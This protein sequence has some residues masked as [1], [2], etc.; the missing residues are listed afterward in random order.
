MKKVRLLVLIAIIGACLALWA[1]GGGG[2]G[3]PP[4]DEP[5]PGTAVDT[6]GD[7]I[8]DTADNCSTV[9]NADQTDQILADGSAGS[10]GVGD[11]CE[12]AGVADTYTWI[13]NAPL[14]VD[15]AAQGLLAN[16]QFADSVVNFGEE[17]AFATGTC[18][19]TNVDPLVAST[20]LGGTVAIDAAGLFVYTPPG[21]GAAIP[22]AS[23]DGDPGI[24]SDGVTVLD[25]FEIIPGSSE[26]AGVNGVPSPVTVT[27]ADTAWFVQNN[28]TSTTPDGSLANPF[29]SLRGPRQP[30]PTDPGP[31]VA[32]D[33]IFVLSGDGTTTGQDIGIFLLNNQKLIGQGIDLAYPGFSVNGSTPAPKTIM[34][35]SI[36]PISG[37]PLTAGTPPSVTNTGLAEGGVAV[38][39]PVEL[40][41]NNEVAGLR[42]VDSNEEKI[43]G[44]LF[45][46][47]GITGFN[48]HHNV[49]EETAG[50][51]L[52]NAEDIFLF[53]AGGTGVV[54][55]NT[56]TDSGREAIRFI[57]FDPAVPAT[58]PLDIIGTLTITGNTITSP[59]QSGIHI[60]LA[61]TGAATSSLTATIDGGNSI[62]GIAAGEDAIDVQLHDAATMN[63]TIDGATLTADLTNPGDQGINF[64][65]NEDSQAS[66]VVT[67]TSISGFLLNGMELQ[68]NDDADLAGVTTATVDALVDGNTM[69]GNGTGFAAGSDAN[70]LF[71]L[72]LTSN[73]STGNTSGTGY[74]ITAAAAELTFVHDET[75]APNTGDPIV[76]D[77][78][79]PQLTTIGQGTC[80]G[81]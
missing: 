74:R 8:A 10:N 27:M 9:A 80:G 61:S 1:C 48:I 5:G 65:A 26:V 53:A 72:E 4:T 44:G 7:G 35:P 70:T 16:A 51:P 42:L 15:A 45:P 40:A 55:N 73:S 54:A 69:T 36:N 71:C 22:A 47:S 62:S 56:M 12:P 50:S 38:G 2:G 77:A 37:T 3:I 41:D 64:D 17:C 20:R 49:F 60:E 67:G 46:D 11:V 14:V 23:A 29:P 21:P 13:R 81:L 57:N 6:D 32:G 76:V 18:V 28:T 34:M 78:G 31:S 63:L 66:L 79:I 33:F 30:T 58:P 52:D 75:L 59:L 24:Q 25:R 68:T 43:M 19:D 39:A